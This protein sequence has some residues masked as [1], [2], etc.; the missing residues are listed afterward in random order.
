M[1]SVTCDCHQLKVEGKTVTLLCA[2]LFYFRLPRECW[3]ERMEQ[4]RMCGYNCI[5]VYIPWNFHESRPGAWRFTGMY[6]VEAFLEMAHSHGLYVIARPGPYICSEWDGGALPAWL[7]TQQLDLR[8]KDGA[9]LAEL[10]RWLEK[11]L[12]MLARHEAGRGGSIVAVQLENELDF[13]ACRDPKG[14]MEHLAETARRCGITVPL[15][16]CAGQC[17]IQSASGGA[18]DI[19]V[20]FNA[21]ASATYRRMEDQLAHMRHMAV[22][23][24]TPLM[25]TETDREHGKLK[26]ELA[27]CA[28]LIAPYN[29]VGGTDIDMTNSVG[30]WGSDLQRPLSCM[31]TDYDFVS[32]ITADGRLRPEAAQGRLM[33]NMIASLGSQ[34]AQSE[35][36]AAPVSFQ[37]DFAT[38]ITQDAQGR[39]IPMYP[40]V[41]LPTGYIVGASNLGE[42]AGTLRFTSPAGE[43]CAVQV[44][45]GET[46]LLPWQMQLQPWGWDGTLVCSEAEWCGHTMEEGKLKLT[47]VGDADARAWFQRKQGLTQVKGS[48]WQ[49][50]DEGLC[51]R[52]LPMEEAVSA[53][54]NLPPLTQQIPSVLSVKKVETVCQHACHVADAAVPLGE[55]ICPMEQ[56]QQYRG[57][58]LYRFAAQ[59]DAPL[60]LEKAADL[61]WITHGTLTRAYF[62]DGGNLLL[63]GGRGTWD[64]RV[65]SWGHANFDDVRQPALKMGSGKGLEGVA[66]LM[67]C[68][69]ISD[70]WMIYPQ[71]KYAAQQKPELRESDA[72]M[73]T[74][75][76]SWSYP[77]A[78]MCADFVRRV[79][80][81]EN[82]DRF[83]LYIEG[84][85]SQVAVYLNDQYVGARQANDPWVDITT[86][87]VAGTGAVLRLT[88]TRRFSHTSLGAI[89]LYAGLRI[90]KAQMAGVPVEAWQTLQPADAGRTVSLPVHV[91][92]GE[93][94]M[95]T[96]FV[97]QPGQQD[98]MLVIE[99][100][101]IEATLIAHGHV[102]GR[103]LRSAPGYPE[104]TGG[105]SRRIYLPA[106]WQ[107]D[108]RLHVAGIGEGGTLTGI[109]WE[110]IKA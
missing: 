50:V 90:T 20:T 67:S 46:V 51:V 21:Y 105:S 70:L 77:A 88:T 56:K 75:I 3:E 62:C 69:D 95:L 91:S 24:D 79:Y 110:S 84:E 55:T 15:T 45:P 98:R 6:D 81:P 28:R 8:Q 18:Q 31:A 41:Q 36:C 12:P 7:Y 47:L 86:M 29:Q 4:L 44:L 26:R 23:S 22:Q 108:A 52:I 16:A 9:Y 48:S 89:K 72:I 14:Y 43:A 65:Q 60:L 33:G 32:M 109:L 107:A 82:C 96:G 80:F 1:P 102:A 53:C 57:D 34:L 94:C 71:A 87:A 10:D 99:G 76:N 85:G 40:A 73:A 68:Q 17:D 54:P 101:G 97:P 58:A 104:I 100:T 61:V 78:P 59:Q 11:I 106:S 2:S 42:T 25:I 92:A 5:D 38:A 83:F 35:P 13:F 63:D 39:E 93:E 19:H 74:T 66:Q 27:C 30:N 37:A 103:V 64:I 49:D